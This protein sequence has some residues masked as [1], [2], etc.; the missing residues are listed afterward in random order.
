MWRIYIFILGKEVKI[1]NSPL[2]IQLSANSVSITIY[3]RDTYLQDVFYKNMHG[4]HISWA[5]LMV[6]GQPFQDY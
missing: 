4:P 3:L 2:L 6:F 5:M 1:N